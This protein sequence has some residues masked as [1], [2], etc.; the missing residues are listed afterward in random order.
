MQALVTQWGFEMALWVYETIFFP[1]GQ[2][3]HEV[4]AEPLIVLE[5]LM[6]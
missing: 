4:F 6:M 3:S 1:S 5:L 2:A